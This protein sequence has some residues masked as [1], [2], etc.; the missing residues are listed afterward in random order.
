[1]GAKRTATLA[2]A[3]AA[4]MYF[5]D[6]EMGRTRRAKASDKIGAWFRGGSSEL[7]RKGRYIGSTVEGKMQ[8]ASHAGQET[9]PPN[10]PALA[11]KIESEVFRD[12][13]KGGLNVNVVDGVAF[14]RGE[15]DSDERISALEQAVRKVTGV[16]DV[17]NFVHLPGQ[18][19]PNK[20]PA[21]GIDVENP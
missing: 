1:M 14:L 9:V 2:G 10:D 5:F 8:A 11:A 21:A 20:E 3:G 15:L 6:P 19:A 12:F 4:I 17:Q 7:Q 16:V 18:P 13:P